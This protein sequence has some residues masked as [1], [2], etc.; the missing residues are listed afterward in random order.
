MDSIQLY[1]PRK[2]KMYLLVRWMIL[3]VIMDATGSGE[4]MK[5]EF[6]WIPT[7]VISEKHLLNTSLTSEVILVH[8]KMSKCNVIENTID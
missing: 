1:L 5:L 6:L 3:E 8:A 4:T 2:E 7:L